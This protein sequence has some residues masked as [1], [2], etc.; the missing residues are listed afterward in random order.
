MATFALQKTSAMPRAARISI[1]LFALLVT[2]MAS[3]QSPADTKRNGERAF[4][5]GRWAE[6]Q[7][8]LAQYQEAKPGDFG[9]LTKLGISLFQ[10]G[11]GEEA[12]RY[13]EYVAAKSPDGQDS[14]LFYY[15]A[16]TLHGL[17]EWEKAITAY[18]SFLRVS[19]ER[20]PFRFN[21]TDNIRRCVSGMQI[22]QNEEVAL[23]ENLGDRVNTMGDEFAPIPSVNHADRLYF[24]AARPG[25]TG[26]ERNDEGYEDSQRGHWC[27]DMFAAQL[28]TS[29]WEMQGGLGGLLNT[30][31][32]EV[33]LGFNANG[34]ILYFFRGFTLY[35]GEV[36]ADTAARKDE[37]SINSPA[38]ISPV[39][40]EE[41]DCN[42][43]FF[44]DET[45]VFASRRAGGYGGLDLWWTVWADSNWTAPVNLG[46]EVNSA[47]DEDMPFLANNGATLFF[48]SNRTEGMGGLDVFKT[49]FDP[50]KRVWQ[51]PANLGLP[52]NSPE[53]DTYYRLALDGRSAFFA[54]N[55]FGG[56]GQRDLYIAYFKE[57]QPEQSVA[58]QPALFAQADPNAGADQEL[59]EIVIPTLSYSSDKDVMS[60]DNQKVVDQIAGI[61]R[62]FPQSSVLVT[63]HTDATGLPKFDLYNGIKRA[64]IIGKALTD[65]GVP[66]TKILLRS[67]GPNY[68]IAREVLD[69]TPNPAAP[70][71]NRRID[72]RLTAIEPSALKFRVEQPFVS[73]IMAAPGAQ[74]LDEATAGL[75]YTVE[76]ASTRQILTNDALAMFGDLRIETQP[77]LG[78]YRYTTGVFKQ[79]SA[80]AQLR[81]E[82]LSQG[83]ADATVVAYIN[84]IRIS[85]AE[86]VALLKKYPDLAGY[87]RG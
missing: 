85:K 39:Q 86:A 35:S 57:G 70:G 30:S 6:A 83:F 21:A 16:R 18:K 48:S 22:V 58:P 4:A 12:R 54:S 27:S 23:V 76:A 45:I 43:F 42:P 31:R 17:A 82:V 59:R 33:P 14:E 15:L 56:F 29:G 60:P 19:S 71:L 55:R 72:L 40:A 78:A 64:E 7:T 47:Y 69:A 50:K 25:S 62:N 46:P 2:G 61:A 3:A 65:R 5:A 74:R 13:L 53:D 38:F 75:S 81:K 1:L 36:L 11:R 73:E 28:V 20:H 34:Q 9:V 49:I 24:A 51:T 87:V 26:G 32:F 10:L 44:N 68:P 67:V 63:V 84:G 79:F 52:I 41:G 80:A 37:Y 66:A 77:G 8:K